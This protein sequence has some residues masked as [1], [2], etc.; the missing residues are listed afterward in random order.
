[1]AGGPELGLILGDKWVAG[2]KR[3]GGGHRGGTRR[4]RRRCSGMDYL[5]KKGKSEERTKET[6]KGNA[7]VWKSLE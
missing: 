3:R 5:T 7:N 1:M 2:V 6:N 4:R